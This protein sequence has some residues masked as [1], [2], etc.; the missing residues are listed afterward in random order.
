MQTRKVTR[1]SV[2]LLALVAALAG[3][4]EKKT[5]LG[6]G[7]SVVTGSAG[8][9][10]ARNAARELVR[11]D[12]PVATLALAENPNGYIMGSGYQLPAS[13]VPLIKLLAQQSGCFRVV[14]RSAGLRGTVQEQDLKD[15]GVLRKNST[16]QKG[17]GYEAQYTLTPSLTFSEQD[18][19]RGLS[20]VIAMIPVLRD[21]AG[22]AG[23]V[24]QVKFKEAQTALLLSDNETTE[25]VAAS[26]GAARSTDLGVGGLV[27][28]KLGGAAGA[29][30]SNTNEGKVIAAAFLD[31]H[32]QLV[33]Q[34]RALQAKEMPPPVATARKSSGS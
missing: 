4:G 10:G 28:G 32:N 29:G 18:A 17:R 14:D 15:A 31:A 13:P 6:Q 9:E 8:P 1:L 12:A 2:T 33:T 27:F 30:W 22:L 34:V 7:G 3:C 5:E 21:I 23:L 24:E 11:C 20:G 25:Q 19:G 26:T 16:V